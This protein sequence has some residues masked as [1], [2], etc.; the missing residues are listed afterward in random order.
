MMAKR[1]LLVLVAICLG[2]GLGVV[3]LRLERERIT[4]T[5]LPTPGTTVQ[6]PLTPVAAPVDEAG[7]V[8]ISEVGT[9]VIEVATKKLWRLGSAFSTS[10]VWSRDSL[11]R[12]TCCDE[13]GGIDVVDL[14]AG[15]THR[16]FEGDVSLVRPSPDGRLLA[17]TQ[18]RAMPTVGLY[19]LDVDGS[20]L[21]QLSDAP[22][23][24]IRWSPRG[25]YIAFQTGPQGN[26]H[27]LQAAL[28]KTSEIVGL[29]L[30]RPIT[31][32]WS[33]D[34]QAVAMGGANGLFLHAADTGQS[35]QL[36]SAP[37]WAV[38]LWSPGG[39]ELLRGDLVKIVTNAGIPYS[40]PGSFWLSVI[41]VASGQERPLTASYRRPAWSPDGRRIA[42]ISDGC[43][44]GRWDVYVTSADGGDPRRLTTPETAQHP[45]SVLGGPLWSPDGST[46][47]FSTIEKVLLADAGTGGI[48]PL[49]VR[50]SKRRDPMA[51]RTWSGDGRYVE[52][53]LL[54]A[55]V[56]ATEPA[57]HDYQ[58]HQNSRVQLSPLDATSSDDMN[59]KE[60]RADG[61]ML[62]GCRI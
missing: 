26:V 57:S 60:R 48:R 56:S 13:P 61:I 17:F 62:R 59:P 7:A 33:P 28:G 4:P 15:F 53:G 45:A 42:Y 2:V 52:F 5:V 1:A 43:Q 8:V 31:F 41:D 36:S 6:T 21:R 30:E 22:I 55:Q 10:V 19:V 44:T 32:A 54:V 24:D 23:W 11:L 9:Y 58:P 37:S 14:G 18:P 51:V 3:S 38:L 46:I 25:D 40:Y 34:S 35:R 20:S 50:G 29:G 16:I 12:V 39:A 27:L 49:A 47:V